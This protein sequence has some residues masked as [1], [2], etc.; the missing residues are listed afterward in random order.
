[1]IFHIYIYMD[2]MSRIIKDIDP[3]SMN[4]IYIIHD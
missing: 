2:D 3:L 1:M 4:M